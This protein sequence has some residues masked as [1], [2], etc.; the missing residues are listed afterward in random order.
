[1]CV[2]AA[3]G[4]RGSRNEKRSTFKVIPDNLQYN[5]KN[6]DTGKVNRKWQHGKR[7]VVRKTTPTK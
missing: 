6:A 3:T 5:M 7:W 2:R 4:I 1:M